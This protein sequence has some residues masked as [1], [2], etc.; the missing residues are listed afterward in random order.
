M[1]QK[2]LT[3]ATMLAAVIVLSATPGFSAVVDTIRANVPFSFMVG[4]TKLPAGEYEIIP[5]NA[6]SL[7]TLIIRQ[8]NGD[9]SILATAMP[10]SLGIGVAPKTELIFDKVGQDEF[11]RQVW[12]RGSQSGDQFFEPKAEREM[13]AQAG[14]SVVSHVDGYPVRTR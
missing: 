3:I 4:H 8:L 6:N 12:E 10:V 14:G 11:L 1:K 13:L 5:P 9:R 2:L 7:Y